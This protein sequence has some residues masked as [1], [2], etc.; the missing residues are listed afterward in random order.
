MTDLAQLLAASEAFLTELPDG[1]SVAWRL[2][3]VSEYNAL[4]GMVSAGLLL[5]AQARLE[6]VRLCVFDY[7]AGHDLWPAGYVDALGNLILWYSGDCDPHTLKEDITQLKNVYSGGTPHEHMVTMILCAFPG[8]RPDEIENWSR[9]KMLKV[10]VQA[11]HVMYYKHAADGFEYMDPDNIVMKS[12]REAE[13]TGVD[14]RQEIAFQREEGLTG[15]SFWTADDMMDD[16]E[17]AQAWGLTPEQLAQ[18]DS[19]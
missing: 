19:R 9:N 1:F 5:E 3:T 15:S 11:E 4:R 7:S 14:L 10:F 18:L 8:I 2:L 16:E 12:D 17:A 6:A 13:P